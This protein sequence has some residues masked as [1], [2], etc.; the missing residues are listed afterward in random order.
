MDEMNMAI[1]GRKGI[2]LMLRLL[3]VIAIPMLLLFAIAVFSV[4]TVSENI[5]EAMVQHELNAAQYAFK[6]AVGNI[7]SGTYMYTNGKFYKGKRNISD[8]LEF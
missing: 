8:N 5:T 1:E 4:K 6:T 2:R 7:A 3:L